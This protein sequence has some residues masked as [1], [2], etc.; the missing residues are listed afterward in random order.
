[1]S[2]GVDVERD[3]TARHWMVEKHWIPEMAAVVR[4][5]S[6]KYVRR[7]NKGGS[8][9]R[10]YH[11]YHTSGDIFLGVEAGGCCIQTQHRPP[12]LPQPPGSAE[13][14]AMGRG[15]G[16]LLAGEER[17]AQLRH[18]DMRE[19]FGTTADHRGMAWCL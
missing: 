16:A 5:E 17:F 15:D 14:S 11:A 13:R 3:F 4:V 9:S 10:A 2:S 8:R 7:V 12:G 18:N 6:F 19:N 1:M